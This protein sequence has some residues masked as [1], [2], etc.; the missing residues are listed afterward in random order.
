MSTETKIVYP[1]KIVKAWI[2][3][4]M[5]KEYSITVYPKISLFGDKFYAFLKS[6]EVEYTTIEDKVL[7]KC[8]DPLKIA[9]LIIA[10]EN[11]GYFVSD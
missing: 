4:T 7:I 11:M 8:K 6:K 1:K 5:Q 10:L 2:E 3:K 9:N